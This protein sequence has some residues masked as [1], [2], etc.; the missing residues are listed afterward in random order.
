[1]MPP[2][3][4]DCKHLARF[5]PGELSHCTAFPDEIPDDIFKNRHDHRQPY[6]GDHG[7]RFEPSES[8]IRLRLVSPDPPYERLTLPLDEIDVALDKLAH[9]P[10]KTKKGRG[11]VAR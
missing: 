10:R 3:C 7:I 4:F 5:R 6:P 9:Q 1:M 2:Q 11:R 8:A